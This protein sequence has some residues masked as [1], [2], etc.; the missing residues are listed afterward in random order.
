[1]LYR[2]SKDG[3]DEK[4]LKQVFTKL[5]EH[6]DALRMVY[7]ISPEKHRGPREMMIKQECSGL[8]GKLFDIEVFNIEETYPVEE[9]ETAIRNQANRIQASINLEKGPLVKLGLFKTREGDHLLVVIHHLVVDG[10]SWRI[11][12]EDFGIAY[13]QL[14][15][16][17]KIQLQE[18][19]HSF[20]YWSRELTAYAK[21]ELLIKEVKYWKEIE[22]EIAKIKSLP[23]D[24]QIGPDKKKHKYTENVTI[25]LDKENTGLL[26]RK[27]NEVYNTEI[28]D[29]LLTALGMVI[30]EWTGLDR[31]VIN[32]EGHGRESIVEGMDISRT[33]GWFTSLFPVILDMG[34]AKDISYAIRH[35]KEILRRVPNKGIGYGILK[36]LTPAAKKQA[37]TDSIEFKTEPEIYF[38]YLGQFGRDN[39]NNNAFIKISSISPGKN[40]S[41][42]ME[43][44]CTIDI[45]GM[46]VEGKLSLVFTYNKYEYKKDNLEKLAAGYRSH[47]LNIIDHC[48]KKEE[49]ELTPSDLGYAGIKIEEI[50][51]FEDEFTGLE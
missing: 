28:N 47:L 39:Q 24:W 5:V 51:A 30:K 50:E 11:L 20:Q 37:W 23:K 48:S 33:P 6:H 8:T 22:G 12:L 9:M 25:D 14:E 29:I 43:R 19:T 21:S 34:Q 46:V 26:L 36:Y 32:L 40:I 27:V 10:I 1:M 31:V 38:N 42:G 35:V 3:F 45:N 7:T 17:K 2:D 41:P 44:T 49:Q 16:E 18:K 4:I 15:Q 13:Q